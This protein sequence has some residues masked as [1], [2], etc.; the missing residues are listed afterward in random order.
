MA[1]LILALLFPFLTTVCAANE[2]YISSN[3]SSNTSCGSVHS[4]CLSLTDITQWNNDTVLIIEGSIVLDS[5]IEINSVHNLSFTSSITNQEVA[6]VIKCICPQY[7]NC[8]LIIEDSQNVSFKGL[9]VTGCSV[10]HELDSSGTYLYRS[11]ITI[12]STNNISL[13]STLISESI[14]TGLLLINAAGNINITNSVF[15]NNWLPYALQTNSNDT[16]VHGGA[17]LAVLVSGCQATAHNCSYASSGKYSIQRASF[18]NNT[19]NLTSFNSRDWL[20]SFGGGLGILLIW[21][22]RGNSFNIEHSNFSNNRASV[23]GGIAWHCKTL[24]LDNVMNVN[25]CLI[26]DNSLT[27]PSFGGAGMATGIA[28]YSGDTSTNNNVT[29]NETS[30][31][32]N[33][34]IYGGGVLVYCNAM[35]PEKP[36]QAYNYVHF[37]KS[38]WVGNSGTVSPAVEVE[39]N[40][41]SQQYSAFTTKVIFE[42]CSY[43][44]NSI[45]RH[46][47]SSVTPSYTFNEGIGVFIITRL[48][49]HFRGNNTFTGNSG[50]A[51][52]I[53][54]GSAFFTKGAVTMF[55]NNTGTNGGALG[56]VGY[57]NI[58]YDNDTVFIF[59]GNRA[60][61]IGGAIHVLNAKP[62]SSLS[63]HSCFLQYNNSE[64]LY[65][66]NARFIFNDNWSS[67]CIANSIFLTTVAPCRFACLSQ[68]AI[69][70]EP[71]DIFINQS[72]IGTFEFFSNDSERN[73]VASGGSLFNISQSTP[74][75]IIPGRKYYLPLTLLDDMGQDV[76][77]ITIFQSS[78]GNNSDIKL[79]DG[80]V[81]NNT[82]ELRGESG[83]MSNLTL[84][85]T[86]YQSKGVGASISIKLSSC[87]PGY[88]IDSNKGS[89]VCSAIQNKLFTY[90]GIVSCDEKEGVASAIAGYWVGYILSND[91][92]TPNQYNLYTAD[93]PLGFCTYFNKTMSS[94]SNQYY[95]LT[96]TAS[97]NDL[98]QVVC[99]EN[100][101]G[102]ACS[103]CKE[104]YSVYFHSETNKCGDSYLCSVGII[105][106]I[107]SEIIPITFLFFAIVF[108]N[109]SLTTGL[110]YN[111]LFMIQLLQAMIVSVNGGVEFKPSFIRSIYRVIYNMFNLDF[112]DDDKLSFCLWKGARTL[113]MI[114]IKYVSVIYAVILI[115]GFVYMFKHCTCSSKCPKVSVSYSAVQGL[116]AFLVISYFQCSRITFLILDKETPLGIGGSHYKDIVFWDGSLIYFSPKHLQYAIPA[117]ICLIFF[118]IPFPLILMF[119]GLLLKCESQLSSRFYFIRRS[120][121]W[122]KVHYRMKPLL[123]S[124]QGTFKDQ[125]RFFSGLYFL[126]RILILTLL[127]AATTPLQYYFL[128]E[129]MLIII[130]I[131]QAIVQPFQKK[132]HNIAALLIF[133]N[134]ALINIFTLRIYNLVSMDGD[135]AETIALQWIQMVLIYVPLVAGVMWVIWKVHQKFH[136]EN[137]SETSIEENEYY[138][139]DEDFP[140][141]VFNRSEE[142]F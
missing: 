61:F 52:Y 119:N 99:A 96:N 93:C 10:L 54:T 22:A 25:N 133:S 69:I 98:E 111:F 50:T 27:T 90:H 125:Y 78:I 109:I 34:G 66:T 5:V 136:S 51:L 1:T 47:N 135:T 89:C 77:R 39:P 87:P 7:N 114:S 8:G 44:N 83:E 100:R 28:Q 120:M 91:T 117:I 58:Q 138:A 65:P 45:R 86:S 49:V 43:T 112:F 105:F 79:S 142:K 118:V 116:T 38:R 57:S 24:C 123:D 85:A 4:P 139:Y 32:G 84:T 128:L 76:T 20:F 106:Y 31:I 75:S 42:D 110:A 102:T 74:L 121:P 3:G 126:Y 129:V 35:D 46:Y 108:F 23:G 94:K 115:M 15:S 55:N 21:N 62:H 124:F 41:K 13:D 14:G 48:T 73:E 19:N 92:D 134:M 16:V 81:A 36:L 40:F 60:S 88:V 107:L 130:I 2:V 11:A 9:S 59:N 67:T 12:N 113:D 103:Q 63:S 131:I 64:S 56:L 6:A 72:C 53:L 37:I 17:G 30:F 140:E 104:G 127:D 70:P 97:K 26:Q 95:S 80:F 101:Q 29:V 33:N 18:I 137:N 68:S 82:I 132:T 122:T 71:K 141:D